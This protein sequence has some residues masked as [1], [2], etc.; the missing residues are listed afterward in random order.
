MWDDRK[1]RVAEDMGFVPIN[2]SQT[3]PV[4][5]IHELTDGRG[6]ENIIEAC[7]LPVTFLQALA[8]AARAGEVVFMGNITGEF[9]IGEKDFSTILRRELKI[10]GTWN[11]KIFPRGTDDWTTVLNYMDK[12]LIVEPLI[13]DV[14]GLK[15]GPEVFQSIINKDKFHNKVIF[16]MQ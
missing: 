3:D 4:A 11:S 7:G 13:T 9:T 14:V 6:A 15:Q 16:E 5:A 12:E 1:L 2:S 10:Y 8:V